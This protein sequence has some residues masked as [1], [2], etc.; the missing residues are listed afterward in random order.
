MSP[1]F[2]GN[3]DKH[4]LS[5]DPEIERTLHK[6]RKQAR[7][8]EQIH[9]IPFEEALQGEE[10][11]DKTS[12]NMAGNEDHNRGRKLADFLIPSATSC[13]SSVV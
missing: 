12:D 3:K 9:E 13:G 1:P 8:Q 11:A 2:E 4:P 10:L 6:L 7:L 5:F